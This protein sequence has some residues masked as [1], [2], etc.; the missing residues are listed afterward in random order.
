MGSGLDALLR[1]HPLRRL[2]A[3][4]FAVALLLAVVG[5]GTLVY[6]QVGAYVW[7]ASELRLRD[8][9]EAAVLRQAPAGTSLADLRRRPGT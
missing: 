4:G 3:V 2:L 1:R 6:A 7:R 5:L 8:E 9:A